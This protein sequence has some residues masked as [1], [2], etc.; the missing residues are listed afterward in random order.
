MVAGRHGRPP[1]RN[2]KGELAGR[3][4]VLARARARRRGV[5]AGDPHRDARRRRHRARAA[6]VGDP[7]GCTDDR[8]RGDAVRRCLDVRDA[9]IP[10]ARRARALRLRAVPRGDR[11]AAA[12]G[13]GPRCLQRRPGARR[14]RARLRPGGRQPAGPAAVDGVV[15]RASLAG[16]STRPARTRRA[17]AR[18]GRATRRTTRRSTTR[19]PRSPTTGGRRDAARPALG[20]A[21][22][23]GIARRC[24]R[25]VRDVVP[26]RAVAGRARL[27]MGR[28]WRGGRHAAAVRLHRGRGE[29]RLDPVRGGLGDLLAARP[30]RSGAGSTCGS[31]SGSAWRSGSG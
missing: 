10:R 27:G 18:A 22:A 13:Q 15:E 28:G 11:K 29:Q 4:D 12:P 1:I 23:L 6:H 21:P 26:S 9:A 17:P 14:T 8:G 20:D 25:A 16:S 19:S 24:H 30:R 5:G 31:R 2:R 3:V 7:D